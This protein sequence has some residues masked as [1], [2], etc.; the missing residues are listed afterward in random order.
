MR[1]KTWKWTRALLPRLDKPKQTCNLNTSSCFNHSLPLLPLRSSCLS[2]RGPT[3]NTFALSFCFLHY[4]INRQPKKG[5]RSLSFMKMS[6][7][8][9][10]RF[11]QSPNRRQ[12]PPQPLSAYLTDKIPCDGHLVPNSVEFLQMGPFPRP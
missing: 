10:L 6:N 12:F 7:L 1:C 2:M 8:K 4:T 5:M 11:H 9:C 3:F